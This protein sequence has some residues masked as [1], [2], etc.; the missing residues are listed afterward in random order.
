MHQEE[1]KTSSRT[2]T[3]EPTSANLA[4]PDWSVFKNMAEGID[5][6]T[7]AQVAGD[8]SQPELTPDSPGPVSDPRESPDEELP[9]NNQHDSEEGD[10]EVKDHETGTDDT[11]DS[12]D[13]RVGDTSF[14]IVS[15]TKKS[16]PPYKYDPDKITL[17]FL[18]ANRDGLTVTIQCKPSDTVGDVKGALLSVW[19][20]GRRYCCS[21]ICFLCYAWC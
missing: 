14:P 7:D 17:R 5:D 2:F 9:Q 18:F 1:L 19:P 8:S 21:L 16:R 4:T 11:A 10:G 3:F 20:K 6:R 13:K 15:S 12:E